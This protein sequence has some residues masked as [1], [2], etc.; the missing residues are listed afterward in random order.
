MR[1]P[2]TW[3]ILAHGYLTVTS[4]QEGGDV[5]WLGLV[6]TYFL[7]CRASKLFTYANGLVHP[8]FCL[9]R[10]CLT[11]FRG[12][13]QVDIEDRARA[14]SVKV[15]FVALKTDQNR[16][17]CTTTRVGMAEG[18][19]VGKTPVGAFKALVELLDAHPRLPGG[20]PLMTRRTASGWKAITRTEAVVALRMM[21]ASAG[22]N[23][24]QF[25]LHSGRIGGATKLA[26]QVTSELQI[27]RADRWKSR[28]F[29][30]YMVQLPEVHPR[31]VR[32][33]EHS[34][35]AQNPDAKS[36]GTRDNAV[37]LRHVEPARVPL[38][39]AAPSPPQVLDSL[40]RLA[41][42]QSHRPPD[43]LSGHACQDGK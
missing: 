32:P 9:T 18:A 38:R 11:F 15:L 31:T 19:G 28:A 35:R 42:V 26:A 2:L 36:R 6:L 14:D 8:D 21:A 10:D 30:V 1:L 3:S 4:S 7:L 33:T 25:A 16:G 40:H 12:D 39:H 17:G 23:P 27:Q 34:P 41:K 29:M 20:G 24:A 13:V 5:I 22:T 43:F 37:R